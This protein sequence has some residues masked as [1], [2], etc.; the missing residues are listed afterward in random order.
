MKR[1]TVDLHMHSGYSSDGTFSVQELF[2]QAKENK[3]QAIVIADHDTYE[4]AGEAEEEARRTGILTIPALELSCIDE[5]RMVHILGYGIDT[6]GKHSLLELIEKI[7]KSRI[8]I[9]P[10]IKENLEKEGFYVDMEEVE[11]L[12]YPHPPVITNF[13]N[14]ILNDTRNAGNPKLCVYRQ[15]GSKSDRP[16]IRF[17]KDYLVAGRKGYVPEYI[18]D[19]YTGIRAIR[20]AKGVPVLAHP[21]EW[22]TKKDEPKIPRMLECGLQGMEV[23]TP[24][25]SVEKEVYFKQ[26]A[27]KYGLFQTAGSDYHDEQKKPGHVMGMIKAADMEMFFRL[28]Q[29]I[30][31][32][33][34]EEKTACRRN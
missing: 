10:K 30:E 32:A 1:K 34:A 24:Y 5:N 9:L 12:A 13:A 15:G 23:Y 11:R 21:G 17:I 25:H 22:F 20:E 27:E 28:K 7:Q 19:I 6:K 29:M 33:H 2:R 18:V 26:L 8:D 14:A 3:M 4:A 31:K 16:Y